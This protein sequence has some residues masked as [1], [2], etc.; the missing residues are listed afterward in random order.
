MFIGDVAGKGVS[1]ALL[2]ARITSDLRLAAQAEAEPTRVLGRVNRAVIDRRQY[3]IFVTGVYLTIDVRSRE[4]VI[5]NAGHPP[6]FIR[7]ADGKLNALRDSG[8]AIGF[9]EEATFPE[10]PFQLARGDTLAL[11]TDGVLEAASAEGEQFGFGRFERS[12]ASSEPGP[13]AM[14]ERLLGD[15]RQHVG[16]GAP[17]DDLTLLLLGIV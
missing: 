13:R 5:A 14:A 3:D 10:V 16:K 7:R 4:G 8:T 2:M 12:L 1:A 6:P 9:F 15:L 17:V 11:Y